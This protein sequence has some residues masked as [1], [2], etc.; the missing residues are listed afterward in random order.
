MERQ[1]A[2]PVTSVC[3]C[4]RHCLRQARLT[5]PFDTLG[6]ASTARDKETRRPRSV[7][8]TSGTAPRSGT[9]VKAESD[10]R[11]KGSASERISACARGPGRCNARHSGLR[12]QVA[13]ARHSIQDCSV[14]ASSAGPGSALVA[15]AFASPSPGMS[16]LPALTALHSP[17]W[18]SGNTPF[19]GGFDG[20]PREPPKALIPAATAAEAPRRQG[21]R[22]MKV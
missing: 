11:R 18:S 7:E 6:T 21:G 15:S 17:K 3:R 16:P 14:A 13:S 8:R 19:S 2:A 1:A 10:Q 12:R 9:S 20:M 4:R 5:C 22:L